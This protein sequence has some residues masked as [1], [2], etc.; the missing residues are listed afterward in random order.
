MPQINTSKRDQ[1]QFLDLNSHVSKNNPVRIIDSFCHSFNPIDLGFL[2]KGLSHE[3]RPAFSADILIRLYI[4]GYL[5][6]VRSSRKL[7][8]ECKRNIELWWLLDQQ[9][10]NYKTIADFRKDNQEA[11]YNVF[12]LFRDFCLQQGLYGKKRVAIDGSKFRAQN[13]RKNNYNIRKINQHLDYIENQTQEYL[14]ELDIEDKKDLKKLSKKEKKTFKKLKNRKKKYTKL[15]KKLEASGDTQI[16]TTDADARK[17]PLRMKIVEV[18]Y[19]IQSSVDD[20]HNL[21]VDYHVTNQTDHNALAPLAKDSRE[22]LE[23]D[24]EE[25]LIV[26]ADKGY[27]NGQQM[28]ECHENNIDTLVSPKKT[29]SPGKATHVRKDKFRYDKKTNQ[30]I[31][32]Q[33]MP[34][35][36]QG[37]FKRKNTK[38]ETVNY[39]DRYIAFHSKCNQC[40]FYEDCVNASS[41]KN[42]RGRYIDR[43]EFD[44]AL[45]RNNEQVRLRKNEYRRRQA[46]VEHPFGTIKRQWG[47]THTLMKG[48]QKVDAEFSLILLAYN[49]KRTMSIMGKKKMKKALK[50]LI[51]SNLTMTTV[52]KHQITTLL[53][54]NKSEMNYL[55]LHKSL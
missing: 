22:A 32:P 48:I 18:A 27:Y 24:E 30:Y 53:T 1:L 26:L 17:L 49:F 14:S 45:E 46:I 39:F 25:E 42:K 16:S 43:S 12:V 29:N 28:H 6:G 36:H 35:N 47:F 4:Y 15:K 7:E 38:G 40:P 52:I 13:S 19:N 3:G 31:C 9:C 44:G 2:V 50:S 21:I 55:L 33:G 37:R 11:F 51:F 54:L 10:P 34:L 20:K 23:L 41:R 5:N 8:A